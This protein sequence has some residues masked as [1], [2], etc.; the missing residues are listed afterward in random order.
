M[1]IGNSYIIPAISNLP[2]QSPRTDGFAFK[3]KKDQE[4]WFEAENSSVANYGAV[5]ISCW[6][7][8]PDSFFVDIDPGPPGNPPPPN[9]P[10]IFPTETQHIL[11]KY[12][13]LNGIPSGYRLL[14]EKG[15]NQQSG[16]TFRRLVWQMAYGGA[17][18]GQVRSF[19]NINSLSANTVYLVTASAA[20]NS[21]RLYLKG[22]NNVLL[23]DVNQI[24]EAV[25]LTGAPLVLGN[26][27]PTSTALEY[28]GDLD[29]VA[30]WGGGFPGI[31]MTE[32]ITNE[33]FNWRINKNL[34]NLQNV[35]SPNYWW[36]MGENASQDA[37]G[38][39]VLPSIGTDSGDLTG[40]GTKHNR[41]SPGLPN[42]LY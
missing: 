33:I 23:S 34:N 31:T 5:A 29:E 20:G 1:F 28:N 25:G 39:W 6:I 38:E 10:Y 9:P 7:K 41:I 21:S 32:A 42:Q 24:L 18:G 13:F 3:F 17:L 36:Q 2:G 27:N 30:I 37:F 22:A 12:S 11:D 35:S 15:V 4:S 40:T 8:L 26:A 16:S 19:V 14:I